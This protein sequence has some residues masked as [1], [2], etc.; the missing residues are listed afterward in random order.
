[1]ERNGFGRAA[2][3]L[4]RARPRRLRLSPDEIAP[5]GTPTLGRRS[6]PRCTGPSVVLTTA[7]PQTPQA[8]PAPRARARPLR[9]TRNSSLL[10]SRRRTCFTKAVAGRPWCASGRGGNAPARAA[11]RRPQR[12]QLDLR[13]RCRWSAR[14]RG[15][16]D[17]QLFITRAS[18][19]AR[20]ARNSSGLGCIRPQFVAH[21]PPP[22][23][24]PTRR[25]A[26]TRRSSNPSSTRT[27]FVGTGAT[28]RRTD[29]VFTQQL[30]GHR[31]PEQLGRP[32]ARR[33]LVDCRARV[34]GFVVAIDSGLPPPKRFLRFASLA[35]RGLDSLARRL[36]AA[37][38]QSSS[39]RRLAAL[40]ATPA[41]PSWRKY[42]LSAVSTWARVRLGAWR[43]QSSMRSQRLAEAR[44]VRWLYWTYARLFHVILR[45][46]LSAT[47]CTPE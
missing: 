39:A 20:A 6:A 30:P 24:R 2:S 46:T 42:S 13:W 10:A 33:E 36:A 28:R 16:A 38:R 34:F 27:R 32:S 40:R 3:A 25:D 17:P 35:Q 31:A 9:L 26:S 8:F 21:L 5:E 45:R 7:P 11:P 23:R 22:Q 43:A 19:R 29:S 37:A 4:P 41:P 14:W 44:V 12:R 47:G 1:V 15:V 18:P